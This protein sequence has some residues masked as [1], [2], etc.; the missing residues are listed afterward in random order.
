MMGAP[1]N[2]KLFAHPEFPHNYNIVTREHIYGFFNE[3]LKL[4]LPEERLKERDYEPLTR[5][6]LAVWDDRHPAPEGGAEFEKQLLKWWYEDA[7]QQMQ[8]SVAAFEKVAR[9]AIRALL[10]PQAAS[11]KAVLEVRNGTNETEVKNW[12]ARE[13]SENT[14][15]SGLCVGMGKPV[16]VLSPDGSRSILDGDHP[17]SLCASLVTQG[18]EV[19]SA[20]LWNQ[21]SHPN[22]TMD[23][24]KTPRVA[25]P[26]E[27]AAY[28]FGY[29]L[30]DVALRVQD[31]RTLIQGLSARN[32]EGNVS[33]IALGAEMAP[34]AA[35]AAALDSGKVNAL[36]VDTEGFRFLNV[37]DIRDPIFLPGGAKYG[38]LPGLLALGAPRKLFLVGE[39]QIGP[40]LVTAAYET[41]GKADT[42]RLVSTADGQQIVRWLKDPAK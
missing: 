10:D 18:F 36:I 6:Q 42:L 17:N 19:W 28:T 1:E 22:N 12:I 20:D 41:A 2:V 27:A 38:D 30:S 11:G 33:V 13:T 39:G 40:D 24:G 16:L 9:P 3:H 32:D 8:T 37:P 4:G 14:Q 23:G 29:N 26:R 21:P 34:I 7:Q 31:V 15:V 25:N 5:E 35:A